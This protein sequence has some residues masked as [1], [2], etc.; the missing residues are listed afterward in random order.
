MKYAIKPKNVVQNFFKI[1]TFKF[2][3]TSFFI[4][5]T[6]YLPN[7]IILC[8]HHLLTLIIH[9]PHPTPQDQVNRFSKVQPSKSHPKREKAK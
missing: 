5:E 1:E 8:L 7:I 4:F 2:K 3:L 6:Y 9:L